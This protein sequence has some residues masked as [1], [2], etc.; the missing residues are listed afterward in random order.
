MNQ[1][2]T[3]LLLLLATALA[4]LFFLLHLQRRGDATLSVYDPP[5]C[6]YCSTSSDSS[7]SLPEL[8]QFLPIPPQ[9][10][11][12]SSE[13]R[14]TMRILFYADILA[15]YTNMNRWWFDF[16]EAFMNR[17]DVYAVL[18]GPGFKDYD[19]KL[20]LCAN[21]HKQWGDP[22]YF[23]FFWAN[24]DP[25]EK[26]RR[27][28]PGISN[29]SRTTP[30]I[31][32]FHECVRGDLL[33]ASDTN[34]IFN[35]YLAPFNISF[36][37]YANSMAYYT[38]EG[39]NNL[40]WHL[41]HVAHVPDFPQPTPPHE[42]RSVDV[43]LIGN[44]RSEYPL[45]MRFLELYKAGRLPGV[46][47]HVQ[48]PGYWLRIVENNTRAVKEQVARYSQAL[49]DAKIVILC[50][51]VRKTAVRKYAE[52]AVA[53]ALVIADIPGER[54]EE[55]RS[56]VVEVQ[57]NDT[58][59]T[60]IDTVKWWLDHPVERAARA[61]KGQILNLEK[62]TTANATQTALVAMKEFLNG[63][64]GLVFPYPFSRVDHFMPKAPQQTNSSKK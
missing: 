41:P 26:T 9:H 58:D 46:V 62:Y 36:H 27:K 3:L 12:A 55:F 59:E 16:V 33:P 37:M 52:V 32:W 22:Q 7:Y 35:C 47:K 6:P 44:I 10:S 25:K 50:S 18:W 17:S 39:T 45:R 29:C 51:T 11:A 2:I 64:R 34:R 57:V 31:K 19:L 40:L 24:T 4:T 5:S 48:H 56:W 53:G 49:M 54:E 15:Y 30:V 28:T 60:L 38:H 21:V 42:N 14:S 23:D 13:D 8:D 43:L 63:R 20:S 1:R 61:R